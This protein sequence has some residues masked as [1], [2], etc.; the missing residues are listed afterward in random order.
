MNSN[1]IHYTDSEL[2]EMQ[3]DMKFD[4]DETFADK[5][6]SIKVDRK[7]PFAKY[8]RKYMLRK[9]RWYHRLWDWIKGLFGLKKKELEEGVVMNENFDFNEWRDE[10]VEKV[11]SSIKKDGKTKNTITCPLCYS[12]RDYY[13][14]SNGH[15]HTSCIKCGISVNQ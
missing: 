11:I 2:D 10:Q 7:D 1:N 8:I 5:I 12:N 4:L 6:S 3:K 14:A 15:I 9:E 13:I